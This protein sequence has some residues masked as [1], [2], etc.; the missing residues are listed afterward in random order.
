MP[1]KIYATAMSGNRIIVGTSGRFINIY[2]V[3]N[4]SQPEF[5]AQ[6]SL[7]YQIRCIASNPENTGT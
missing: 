6:S 4:M 3:R 5:K 1:G 7:K 2:D